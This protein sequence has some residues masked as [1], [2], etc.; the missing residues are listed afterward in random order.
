[1]IKDVG[2]SLKGGNLLGKQN[3]LVETWTVIGESGLVQLLVNAYK[4][5]TRH[6]FYR[7]DHEPRIKTE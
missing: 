5:K 6:Q 3:S 2:S 1:M 4:M 7:I